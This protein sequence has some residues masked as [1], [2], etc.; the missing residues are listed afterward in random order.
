MLFSF[1]LSIY[2]LGLVSLWGRNSYNIVIEDQFV[3]FTLT[4]WYN[5]TMPSDYKYKAPLL[6]WIYTNPASASSTNIELAS[7][8]KENA[9]VKNSYRI[10][11]RGEQARCF[12]SGTS[13]VHLHGYLCFRWRRLWHG[14]QYVYFQI[15]YF[16]N[17]S[18]H[19][20]LS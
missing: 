14:F 20:M 10:P 4:V 18:F 7:K 3:E 2:L 19:I 12:K 13:R 16:F 5:Q 15:L 11:S 8:V 1:F 17:Y 6:D 9:G